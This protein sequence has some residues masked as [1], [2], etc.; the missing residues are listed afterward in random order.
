M[1]QVQFF[2]LLRL[3]LKQEKLDLP[4]VTGENISQLLMRVQQQ[5]PTPFVQKLLDEDGSML[6]GTIIL[7][8]RHNIHHLEGLQTPVNDNDVIAMFPPGA[9]G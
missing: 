7:V 2:S 3:L 4:A 1:V 9:G 8:N 6:A 5:M